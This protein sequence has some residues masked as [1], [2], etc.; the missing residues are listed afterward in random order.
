MNLHEYQAKELLRQF[1]LPLL[2]GKAYINQLDNVDADLDNLQGS[3]GW[4]DPDLKRLI[5]MDLI[6]RKAGGNSGSRSQTLH[7]NGP[8]N[9]QGSPGLRKTVLIIA[10]AMLLEIP[11][12]P[13]RRPI[14]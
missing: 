9:L 6:I 10:C 11:R 13:P 2:V 4:A 7:N 1:N 3:G 12:S 14:E 5:I 8:D